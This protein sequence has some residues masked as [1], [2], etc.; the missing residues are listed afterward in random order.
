[1]GARFDLLRRSA[2]GEGRPLSHREAHALAG[3]WYMWFV[4]QFEDE[5][6]DPEGWEAALDLL[7]AASERFLPTDLG[8]P[9]GGS[10]FYCL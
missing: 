8:G 10:G 5:P 3:E 4:P 7:I 9:R 1:M 6:G 2:R